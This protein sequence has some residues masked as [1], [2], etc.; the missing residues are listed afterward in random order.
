MI[1]C[2]YVQVDWGL[3]HPAEFTLTRQWTECAPVSCLLC[4]EEAENT[5]IFSSKSLANTHAFLPY[6]SAQEGFWRK[7]IVDYKFTRKYVYILAL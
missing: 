2:Q 7:G 3:N 5:R 4:S 1:H 6:C